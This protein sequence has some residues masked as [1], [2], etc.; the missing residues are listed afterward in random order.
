MQTAD[1]LLGLLLPDVFSDFLHNC[2]IPYPVQYV[3]CIGGFGEFEIR[4]VS[5]FDLIYLW[6]LESHKLN[7]WVERWDLFTLSKPS[8][9]RNEQIGFEWKEFS[10]PVWTLFCISLIHLS[11]TL[12]HYDHLP[13]ASHMSSLHL[14]FI[15]KCS[16]WG[17][18][19]NCFQVSKLC[20]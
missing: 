11:S 1:L 7:E 8:G 14:I 4:L 5:S 19:W 13:A 17:N 9:M 12:I 20:H 3:E 6:S 18:I 16:S 2:P 10:R 15:R